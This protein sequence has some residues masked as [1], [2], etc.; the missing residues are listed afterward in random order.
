MGG[1]AA[2]HLKLHGREGKYILKAALEP[3]VSKSILYRPMQGFAVPLATWFRGPLRRRLREMLCAAVLKDSGLFDM[4]IIE[5]LLDRHQAGKSDY[6]A[7]LWS[8][9][10]FEAF[11]RQVHA[12]VVH[13]G[14]HAEAAANVV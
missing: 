9:L 1:W 13:K 4:A 6:S 10:M 11:L 3:H 14:I 5:T 7:A 2:P 12:S 8:L